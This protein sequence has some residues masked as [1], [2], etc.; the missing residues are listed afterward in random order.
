[1][2]GS[3]TIN[4]IYF[5]GGDS[6]YIEIISIEGQTQ[7]LKNLIY[8]TPGF[9]L[10][11]TIPN[12]LNPL[13]IT[14]KYPI[15]NLGN[16]MLPPVVSLINYVRPNYPSVTNS[17]VAVTAGDIAQESNIARTGFN[18]DG[19]GVKVCVLSDSYNTVS[20]NNAATDVANGDLPGQM[21]LLLFRL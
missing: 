17:G 2:V 1:M 13:I 14:G 7:N 6:V 8:Q 9:G 10:T 16:L 15:A 20:G 3:D 19:S 12:G 11:D 21:E 4:D 5:F 18:V